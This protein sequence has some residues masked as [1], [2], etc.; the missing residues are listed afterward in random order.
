MYV[1]KWEKHLIKSKYE[2]TNLIHEDIISF[3]TVEVLIT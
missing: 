1:L 3:C 2:I